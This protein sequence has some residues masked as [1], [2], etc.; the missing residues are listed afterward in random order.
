M[1]ANI[2]DFETKK[3]NGIKFSEIESN[4]IE[5]GLME[6]IEIDESDFSDFI[7]KQKN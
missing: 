2:N 6:G 7:K 1:A 4:A 3:L 5:F